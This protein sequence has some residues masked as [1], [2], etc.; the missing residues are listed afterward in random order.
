MR[1]SSNLTDSE[2]KIM[3]ALWEDA[4]RTLRQLIDAVYT[5]TGW[6][7]HTVISFLKRMEQKGS[8]RVDE[9]G[10]TKLY[11]PAIDKETVVTEETNWMIDKL[12]GG[13][14]QLLVS[15][16]VDKLEDED[17]EEMIAILQKARKEHDDGATP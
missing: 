13:N 7:K 15:N 6:S 17:I 5:D 10:P 8:V 12:Y 3:L 4:P 11:Y 2:W 14:S 9:A 1:S 16:M